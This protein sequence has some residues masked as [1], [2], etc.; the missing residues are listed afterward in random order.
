MAIQATQPAPVINIDE[1]E[2]KDIAA[3][4]PHMLLPAGEVLFEEGSPSGS[5]YIVL[6]GLLE[7][8]RKSEGRQV[9]LGVVGK[10]ELIGEMSL[11]QK[12]PRTAT[13]RA[14]TDSVLIAVDAD[15]F[16]QV[17]NRCP[18]VSRGVLNTVMLRLRNNEARMF[19]SNA[20]QHW[21][22]LT[23]GVAHELNNPA[24]AISR[25]VDQLRAAFDEFASAQQQFSDARATDEQ[26]QVLGDLQARI[27]ERALR[28]PE[29][30]VM[31]RNDLEY[32]IE[33]RLEK[34]GIDDA[35]E[36]SEPL[37]NM[38]ITP[39]ELDTLA[40][41]FASDGLR[42]AL[43][44]ACAIHNALSLIAEIAVGAAQISGIVG[45]LKGY[46]FLDQAP[47][48]AVN[49]IDGLDNTLL[50]LR[51]RIPETLSIRREYAPDLPELQAYG[52]ELNQV[53]TNIIVNAIQALKGRGEIVIRARCDGE[54]GWVAV[55]IED[56]GP[57]IPPEHLPR[58]FDPFFTTKAPGEGTGLGLNV[59]YNIVVQKH[60]GEILVESKPGRTLFT[61]R[62]PENFETV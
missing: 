14:R 18:V 52:R 55:E 59:S 50:M 62:L 49:V 42:P 47:V 11:L 44:L 39:A 54:P 26:R 53:W 12:L 15:Q 36:F 28:P 17:M 37:V 58:L 21:N 45:A 2:L 9:L 1:S 3:T 56:N 30:D 43:A 16:I 61:V 57:G 38:G 35:W 24:A 41:A 33:T 48:Q 60:R 27:Q 34:E 20:L 10:G 23:A 40:H 31:A 32:E 46:S 29:L 8:L 7:A 51:R 4:Y 6:D 22:E 25:G 19:Q 13:I 5:A